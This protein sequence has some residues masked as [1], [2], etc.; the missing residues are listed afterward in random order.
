MITGQAG[1]AY[2]R[3]SPYKF[4]HNH[5]VKLTQA[6]CKL[7]VIFM[8]VSWKLNVSSNFYNPTAFDQTDIVIMKKTILVPTDFS[9][10]SMELLEH[11][12]AMADNGETHVVLMHAM[13]L[14]DSITELLFFDKDEIVETL[15]DKAFDRCCQAILQRFP[16]ANITLRTELFTGYNQSAFARFLQ[17]NE[18][19]EAVVPD[20][21]HPVR[22]RANSFDPLPFISKSRLKVTVVGRRKTGSLSVLQT[23][24]PF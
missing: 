20:A 15:K 14:S 19:D 11:I 4:I 17:G 2:D 23:S 6:P 9:I 12:A 24:F 5:S 13:S 10:E 7:D 16:N 8:K 18:I 22:N 21:Y 1:K 3:R